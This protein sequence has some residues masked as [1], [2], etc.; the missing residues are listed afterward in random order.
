MS[1]EQDSLADYI[2]T[3][4]KMNYPL[5]QRILVI[6]NNVAMPDQWQKEKMAGLEWFLSI[7]QSE[8]CSIARSSS[9]NRHNVEIFFNKLNKVFE[10]TSFFVDGSRLW[11]V[12]ETGTTIVQKPRKVV[13]G[14]GL[15]SVSQE[16]G[17]LVTT[18]CFINALGNT[19]PPA[20]VFPCTHFKPH[21]IRD[22]PPGTLGLAAP[23]GWMNADLFIDVMKHF[24]QHYCC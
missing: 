6:K 2:L 12:D 17:T 5:Q 21:M 19:I 22:G 3:C 14:K 13:A 16:K 10:R 20:M 11:N 4:S 1:D 15:K 23:S 9:F 18:C 8:A 24:I 7:R